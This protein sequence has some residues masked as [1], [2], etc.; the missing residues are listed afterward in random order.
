MML[1]SHS[2]STYCIRNLYIDSLAKK[3]ELAQYEKLILYKKCR[4]SAAC[5]YK[6]LQKN[7]RKKFEKKSP[8]FHWSLKHALVGWALDVHNPIKK[9]PE[10][11]F[12]QKNQDRSFQHFQL[13]N[14]KTKKQRFKSVCFSPNHPN[15]SRR[16]SDE[17]I[18][19]LHVKY[20]VVNYLSK[21]ELSSK[22]SQ[23]TISR[24]VVSKTFFIVYPGKTKATERK[25]SIKTRC[26]RQSTEKISWRKTRE[27]TTWFF[28][29]LV[30]IFGKNM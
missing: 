11:G 4:N 10:A 2:K 23:T 28:K 19:H 9:R 21:R 1:L 29:F 30:K 24:P 12:W 27:K 8:T 16:I 3:V 20:N 6:Q 13:K 7:M 25:Q 22:Q 26:H 17:G 18:K 5:K 15:K 14:Q